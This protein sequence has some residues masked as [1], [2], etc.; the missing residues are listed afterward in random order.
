MD[1]ACSV[2]V[3]ALR[4]DY[5]VSHGYRTVPLVKSDLFCVTLLNDKFAPFSLSDFL[6]PHI[7][8]FLLTNPLERN[9]WKSKMGTCG[10][11]EWTR[12]GKDG[13]I[14]IVFLQQQDSNLRLKCAFLCPA[15]KPR[16]TPKI[17]TPCDVKCFVSCWPLACPWLWHLQRKVVLNVV[18]CTLKVL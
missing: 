15:S 9:I 8:K 12:R 14:R 6:H 18:E 3:T 2:S 17:L 13:D 4:M 10:W 11:E 1:R 5:L 7:S 16:K